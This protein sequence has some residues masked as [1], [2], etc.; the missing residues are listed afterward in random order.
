MTKISLKRLSFDKENVISRIFSYPRR[1]KDFLNTRK[2]AA[3]TALA[4]ITIFFGM[5]YAYSAANSYMNHGSAPDATGFEK[6]NMQ[7]DSEKLLRVDTDPDSSGSSESS[8]AT[9]KSTTGITATT[10]AV[11]PQASVDVTVNG[12]AVDVPQ[13][14]TVHKKFSSHNGNTSVDVRIEGSGSAQSNSSTSI[15]VNSQSYS[16]GSETNG[17]KGRHQRIR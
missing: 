4:G 16:S 8:S 11:N 3:L 10:N 5:P 13:N 1:L 2:T 17:E 14:G 12:Q 6:K 9:S 7:A 15:E